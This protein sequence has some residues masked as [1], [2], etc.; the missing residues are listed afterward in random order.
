MSK[1]THITLS[2]DHSRHDT[3]TTSVVAPPSPESMSR[4]QSNGP[5]SP[6]S[7]HEFALGIAAETLTDLE[8]VR[9]AI[10]NRLRAMEQFHGTESTPQFTALSAIKDGIAKMEHESELVLK[11][12]LRTHPLGK[13]VK[14]MIGVGEKQGAR[15]IAAIGDPAWNDL[16]E[17]PRRG[18]AELWAY[19]GYAPGQNR[20]KGGENNWNHEA[21]MRA[22]LVAT[23]CIKQMDSPY[24]AAY[25]AAR[26]SWADRDVSDGHKHN[27][28]LRVVAKEVLKDM[29]LTAR[30]DSSDQ[31]KA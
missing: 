3:H 23:S 13:W 11:R 10:E 30:R 9:I 1:N 8:R 25:D 7:P 12:T 21:K 14:G 6:G 20:R 18:P 15:L 31:A 22:Y 24:R 16:D 17:R 27:H 28:A 29:F 2:D 19:C 4:A 26:A 5:S